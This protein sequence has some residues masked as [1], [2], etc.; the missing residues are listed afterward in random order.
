MEGRGMFALTVTGVG[1]LEDVLEAGRR[2]VDSLEHPAGSP[3]V[4]YDARMIL[5]AFKEAEQIAAQTGSVIRL[6]EEG[7]V[8]DLLEPGECL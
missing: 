8:V 5:A 3:A 1:D 2:L 4:I 6:A 7:E